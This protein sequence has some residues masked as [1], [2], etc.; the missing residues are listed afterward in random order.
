VRL[1]L[2]VFGATVVAWC[3]GAGDPLRGSRAPAG[4]ARG[5]GC[6]LGS[7]AYRHGGGGVSVWR[8]AGRRGS[9]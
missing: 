4:H 9:S 1:L 7:R 2:L 3:S 8:G 6:A 5:C